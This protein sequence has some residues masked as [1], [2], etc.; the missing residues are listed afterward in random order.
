MKYGKKRTRVRVYKTVTMLVQQTVD[1]K[2][3]LMYSINCDCNYFEPLKHMLNACRI[4]E[5]EAQKKKQ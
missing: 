3:K 5:K 2:E 4:A 1:W